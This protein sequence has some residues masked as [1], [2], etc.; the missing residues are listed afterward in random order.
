MGSRTNITVIDEDLWKWAKKRAIDME[1]NGVSEYIFK[2]LEKEKE[3]EELKKT[4]KNNIKG[5]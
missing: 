4:R 2:L 3:I 1:C 5:V